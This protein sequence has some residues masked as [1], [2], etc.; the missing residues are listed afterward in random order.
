MLRN[1]TYLLTIEISNLTNKSTPYIYL[2]NTSQRIFVNDTFGPEQFIEYNKIITIK[3]K[4]FEYVKIGILLSKSDIG[5]GFILKNFSLKP[6]LNNEYLKLNIEDSTIATK[7][8][9]GKIF[10]NNNVYFNNLIE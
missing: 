9:Y 10:F 4:Y 2:S 6:I 1:I 5:H 8:F 7:H 3:N